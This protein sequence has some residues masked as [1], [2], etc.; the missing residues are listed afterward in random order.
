MELSH[1]GKEMVVV[2]GHQ[3]PSQLA[4]A[5]IQGLSHIGKA[6]RVSCTSILDFQ[7]P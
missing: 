3:K 1:L 4:G 7:E 2:C 5:H 6:K